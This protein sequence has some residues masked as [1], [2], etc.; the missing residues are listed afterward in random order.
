[1][2]S[3]RYVQF[4]SCT[5]Q[6]WRSMPA[7]D[8]GLAHS[9]A[10]SQEVKLGSTADFAGHGLACVD[11]LRNGGRPPSRCALRWTTFVCRDDLAGLP[12]E[13]R[14]RVGR[15]KVG[16]ERGIRTPGTVSGSVV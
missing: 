9:S 1:M 13:A 15:A 12:T 11:D 6:A 16:G 2:P 3:S 5:A 4:A 7:I 8:G 10:S 14:S